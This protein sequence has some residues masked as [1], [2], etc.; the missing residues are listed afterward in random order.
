MI[1]IPPPDA[2]SFTSSQLS[3]DFRDNLRRFSCFHCGNMPKAGDVLLV[4]MKSGKTGVW[5]VQDIEPRQSGDDS[6]LR[7]GNAE[8]IGYLEEV[9]FTIPPPA[10]IG[11]FL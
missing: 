11:F 7:F 6:G 10:K 8:R 9:T 3:L 1:L 2:V 4:S 5:I